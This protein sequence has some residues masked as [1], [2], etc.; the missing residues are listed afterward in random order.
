VELAKIDTANVEDVLVTENGVFALVRAK[1]NFAFARWE[2]GWK[3]VQNVSGV[4]GRFVDGPSTLLMTNKEIYE[5][6]QGK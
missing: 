4:Y 3:V 5:F 2:N 6:S 1:D